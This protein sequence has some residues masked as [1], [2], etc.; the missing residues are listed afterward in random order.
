M[1]YLEQYSP[2]GNT[3]LKTKPYGGISPPIASC[4]AIG[5]ILDGP[6]ESLRIDIFEWDL[7]NVEPKF[8]LNLLCCDC[9]VPAIFALDKF[10][11]ANSTI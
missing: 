7:G 8:F 10:D 9:G 11:F 4:V 1:V 2:F 3:Y 6:T 5:L